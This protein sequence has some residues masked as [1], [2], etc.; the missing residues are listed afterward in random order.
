MDCTRMWTYAEWRVSAQSDGTR[1]RG[2]FCGKSAFGVERATVV[3]WRSR[4]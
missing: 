4:T 2:Y 3:A 1:R